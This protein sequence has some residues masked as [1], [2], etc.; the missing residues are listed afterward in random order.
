MRKLLS[1]G[2]AVAV[3]ASVSAVRAEDLKSGLQVGESIGAY[4]VEKCAGNENDGVEQGKVLCYRCKL[5]NRPVIAVF[6]RSADD[7]LAA[8]MK[9]LDALVVHNEDKKAA[10]FVNLLGDDADALK[11]ASKSLV[12]KSKAENIAVVVPIEHKNGPEALKLNPDADVTVLIYN[13]GK[14]EAN[15]ALAA[16]KLDAKKIKAI[17]A[18][19]DKILK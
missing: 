18:D 15:H 8:L 7:K 10:S 14:I 12:E 4:D 13:K 5:G 6:A 3:L 19:T 2:L 9:A 1:V 17:I 16:G 11:E